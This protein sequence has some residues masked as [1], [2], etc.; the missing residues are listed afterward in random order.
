MES[1]TPPEHGSMPGMPQVTGEHT[2]LAALAG[3][4][5]G[6]ETLF[7]SPWDSKGG[8]AEGRMESHIGLDGFFLIT[9]YEEV[10]DGQIAYRG[11][12]VYGWDADRRKYT[13][14]WFDSMGGHAPSGPALGTWEGNTLVFD[15]RSSHGHSRYT[16]TIGGPASYTFCIQTSQDGDAWTTF[17][18]GH[19]TKQA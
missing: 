5:R 13:M 7:P 17:M 2:K 4:W 6:N 15:M 19:Y 3:S 16:Y 8:V 12:G 1:P 14:Y 10:R 18:E 11:H 9:Q